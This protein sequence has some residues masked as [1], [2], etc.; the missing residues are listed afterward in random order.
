LNF[1]QPPIQWVPG[2]LSLVVKRLE[3]ESDHSPS[4][5][6]VKKWLKLYL[7]STNTP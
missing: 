3:R 7:H 5:A 2:S 1:F 4:T 6:D